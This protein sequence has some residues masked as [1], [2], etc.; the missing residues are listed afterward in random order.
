MQIVAGFSA[1]Q[2][3]YIPGVIAQPSVLRRCGRACGDC[4][5]CGS[6]S[7]RIVLAALK[8]HFIGLLCFVVPPKRAR[9]LGLQHSN[10]ILLAFVI[11]KGDHTASGLPML[12]PR[13]D[14]VAPCHST[15]SADT[16]SLQ[17]IVSGPNV[18]SPL[19]MVPFTW[20]Q[21]PSSHRSAFCPTEPRVP[22]EARPSCE[23]GRCFPH[24]AACSHWNAGSSP[25]NGR[26]G[27]DHNWNEH[28][29]HPHSALPKFALLCNSMP[30]CLTVLWLSE[31]LTL[32]SPAESN[33]SSGNEQ[34]A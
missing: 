15:V 16:R 18:S 5:R 34:A 12:E 21:P 2:N 31:K 1:S 27:H 26:H 8:N 20:K 25:R 14:E 4:C 28:W 22:L 6:C 32:R 30:V 11:S 10:H 24:R 7:R 29:Y 17:T 13:Q 3:K 9:P 23:E 19:P 33:G